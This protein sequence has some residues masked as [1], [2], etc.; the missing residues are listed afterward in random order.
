MRWSEGRCFP[1]FDT[2]QNAYR[3]AMEGAL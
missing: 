2:M 3:Q 1:D